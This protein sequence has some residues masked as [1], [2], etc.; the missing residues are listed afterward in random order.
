[1]L[2]LPYSL[3]NTLLIYEITFVIKVTTFKNKLLL[4]ACAQFKKTFSSF[5]SFILFCLSAGSISV[6]IPHSTRFV[7]LLCEIKLC[8]ITSSTRIHAGSR[9]NRPCHTCCMLCT[10]CVCM[11]LQNTLLSLPAVAFE[12]IATGH[13]P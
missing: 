8:S 9:S 4:V 11:A 3:Y 5:H 7:R 6:P 12:T 10:A 1:M 13:A 2:F